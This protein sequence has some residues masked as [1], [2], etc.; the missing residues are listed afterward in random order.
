MRFY[1]VLMVVVLSG[2]EDKAEPFYKGCLDYLTKEGFG[3]GPNYQAATDACQKAVSADPTSPSGKAAAAKMREFHGATVKKCTDLAAAGDIEG[4]K[5]ACTMARMTVDEPDLK[6]Q[7]EDAW[8]KI[9]PLLEKGQ[10]DAQNGLKAARDAAR[11]KVEKRYYGHERDG[12]CIDKGLPP[13]RCDLEGGSRAEIDLVAHDYRCEH[14][15][16]GRDDFMLFKV[17][18]CPD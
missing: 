6:K 2:C 8:G 17:F 10:A 4:A 5:S 18:C 11:E 14:L 15:L 12:E 3:G 7:V 16:P 9:N 1:A 13:Y